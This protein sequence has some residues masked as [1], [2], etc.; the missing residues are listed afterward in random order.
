MANYTGIA[1]R[2][3]PKMVYPEDIE[4]VVD[5]TPTAGAIYVG[6]LE[7]SQNVLTLKSTDRVQFRVRD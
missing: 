3:Q 6:N 5:A 1:G 2:I 7:A 4:L